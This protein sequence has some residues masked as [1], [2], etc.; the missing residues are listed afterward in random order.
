M[1]PVV[2]RVLHALARE[3]DA[4][5]LMDRAIRLPGAPAQGVYQYAAGV[6]TDGR[7][8]RAMAVFQLNRRLHPDERFWTCLGLARGYTAVGDRKKAID[9]W[10]V[11]LRNVPANLTAN[12]PAFEKARQAL[13]NAT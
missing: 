1:S 4:D 10:D 9:N 12:V 6:L 2:R 7:K 5:T 11:V 13:K 3:T 8:D